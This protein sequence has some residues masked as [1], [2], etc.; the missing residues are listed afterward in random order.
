MGD[1]ERQPEL[2]G[3]VCA[4][5]GAGRGI[6]AATAKRMAEAGGRVAVLDL[7]PDS[8]EATAESLRA[9]GGDARAYRMDV[10]DEDGVTTVAKQVAADLGGLDVLVN[11]AGI[12]LLGP[13]MSFPL[14]DWQRSLD[15]M[16][17]GVF[18]CSREFG[19]A[20]RDSGGGSIVNIS[21][22]NGL[23]AFPMRLAYSAAK[24]AVNS[25][26]QILAAEWA[27]YRIRVNAVAPGNTRAPMLQKAI[28]EGFIDIDAYMDRTPLG[29]LAE[30]EEIAETILFLASDRSSYVT[31]Q[32][33][34]ADG[35]WTSF[36]W[37]A[38]SGDPESPAIPTEVND[39][40]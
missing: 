16:V 15:V 12:G 17:T 3:K 33:I 2:D 8:A 14:E 7:D 24:A 38:W 10:T 1:V 11:N 30:P 29:R 35:G 37:T 21:S 39:V 26:T 9:A 5:T 13:S 18:L 34:A 36:G 25:M 32:V 27:G 23:V 20:M 19:R 28:D 6:G 31:G 4:V 40:G 22:L